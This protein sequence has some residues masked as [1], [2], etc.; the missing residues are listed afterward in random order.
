MSRVS[1]FEYACPSA[2]GVDVECSPKDAFFCHI[3][4][5]LRKERVN[6]RFNHCFCDEDVVGRIARIAGVT[7]RNSMNRRTL[8]RYLCKIHACW[9]AAVEVVDVE[10]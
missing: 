2:W 5:D 8:D 6:P 4:D 1:E 3:I 9:D 10:G 7:H